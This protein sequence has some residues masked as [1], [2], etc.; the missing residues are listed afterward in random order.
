M[1]KTI[2][3]FVGPADVTGKVPL[4][5]VHT[6]DLDLK[7]FGLREAPKVSQVEFDIGT[8]EWVGKLHDGREI[9]RHVDRRVVINTERQVINEMFARGMEIPGGFSFGKDGEII[10]PSATCLARHGEPHPLACAS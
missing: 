1:P 4:V 5:Y 10:P 7:P 6:D 8:Q 2:D 9:A 3:I